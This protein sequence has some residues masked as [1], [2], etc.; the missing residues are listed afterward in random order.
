M[1]SLKVIPRV[2]C[3]KGVS[4]DKSRMV[5]L[6]K[7]KSLS[8]LGFEYRLLLNPQQKWCRNN[9]PKLEK[10]TARYENLREI[11]RKHVSW[12]VRR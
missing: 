6:K 12:P 4:E 2:T 1:Y 5:Y 3:K 10:R 9:A 7:G 11:F 8:F